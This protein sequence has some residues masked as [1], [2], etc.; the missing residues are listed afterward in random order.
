VTEPVEHVVSESGAVTVVPQKPVPDVKQV[1]GIVYGVLSD[2][3][4]LIYLTEA[5]QPLAAAAEA[6]ADLA[7]GPV[8]T[9]EPEPVAAAVLESLAP[10]ADIRAASE[11]AKAAVDAD[12]LAAKA[13]VFTKPAAEPVADLSAATALMNTMAAAQEFAAH[14]DEV[15]SAADAAD[16]ATAEEKVFPDPRAHLAQWAP[17]TGEPVATITAEP[18]AADTTTDTTTGETR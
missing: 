3:R 9:A 16:K 11:A 14:I 1:G 5:W 17:A 4:D 18:A 12:Y 10:W 6:T 2:H 13:D 8:V 15:A 7:A